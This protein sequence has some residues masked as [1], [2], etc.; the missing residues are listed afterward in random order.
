MSAFKKLILML[1]NKTFNRTV[2]VLFISPLLY[3][4]QYNWVNYSIIAL[5]L[6]VLICIQNMILGYAEL[7]QTKTQ[8]INWLKL[9]LKIINIIVFVPFFYLQ[10]LSPI[11]T[12]YNVWIAGIFYFYNILNYFDVKCDI[13]YIKQIYNKC[14]LLKSSSSTVKSSS[15]ILVSDTS[16]ISI[17]DELSSIKCKKKVQNRSPICISN[18]S[19]SIS[20]TKMSKF[21]YKYNIIN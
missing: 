8:Q 9:S 5:I 13:S 12:K 21:L 11:W 2:W 4:L 18:Y 15:S 19:S 10:S 6:S 1:K 17:S 3:C 20:S 7:V 14:K 16:S